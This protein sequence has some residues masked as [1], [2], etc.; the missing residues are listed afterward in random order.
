MGIRKSLSARLANLAQRVAPK[1]P[2]SQQVVSEDTPG[3]VVALTLLGA[4]ALLVVG[5]LVL[6]AGRDTWNHPG[7]LQVSHPTKA[8]FEV[9]KGPVKVVKRRGETHRKFSAVKRK[10]TV[11]RASQGSGR[12]ETVALATLAT[13]AA[14]LLAGGFAARLT[15]LKLPGVEMTARAAY[16]AGARDSAASTAKVL[17]AA[18]ESGVEDMLEN[19]EKL[20]EAVNLTMRTGIEAGSIAGPAVFAPSVMAQMETVNAEALREAAEEAVQKVADT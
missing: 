20:T 3:W 5:L 16:N 14:L 4:T 11:E 10:K 13:G 2:A 1:K 9:V 8:T 17:A 19:E 7:P 6:I 12:S 18:K 15:S